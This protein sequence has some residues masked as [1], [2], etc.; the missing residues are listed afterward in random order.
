MS[1]R[2]M[3]CRRISRKRVSP[4]RIYNLNGFD[5]EVVESEKDLGV[6][7]ANDTSWKEHIVMIVAKA[8][9]MLGFLK[10]HCGGLVD[11]EA[12]LRLYSSLVRSHLCYCSQVWAPQSVVS[13]LILIEQVQRRATRFIVGKGGDLCYRDRLIQLK[14]LPLNYWLEYL[15]LVFF[16]KCMKGHIIFGRYIDEY[17]SFLRGWSRR[18]STELP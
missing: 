7:I 1:C 4:P 11:S 18:T 13:Q 10:R 17:F 6:M 5:L 8:N 14:I 15:D 2:R 3:S 9:R 12:L 16:Y